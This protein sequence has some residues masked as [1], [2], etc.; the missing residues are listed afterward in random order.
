VTEDHEQLIENV[1]AY[2]LDSLEGPERA[3]MAAHVG[4]CERCASQL[5]E[6]RAVLGSLPIGLEPSEPPAEAWTAIHAAA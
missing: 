5:D 1:A 3:R 2:A 6:Y 4:T